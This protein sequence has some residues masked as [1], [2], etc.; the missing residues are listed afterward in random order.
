MDS[1]LYAILGSDRQI[2]KGVEA[3]SATSAV[4]SATPAFPPLLPPSPSSLFPSA[5]FPTI[6]ARRKATAEELGARAKSNGYKRGV[7]GEKDSTRG[8]GR[9][10]KK[11]TRRQ[12]EVGRPTSNL[13]LGND[14]V[15][16]Y[17][18]DFTQILIDLS[19]V[20][21][22]FFILGSWQIIS[23]AGVFQA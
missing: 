16:F 10:N 6:M 18:E 12:H 22:W 11:T 5:A 9:H 3:R 20:A 4:R 23:A 15:V 8:N 14:T 21:A 7:Y 2:L 19:L 13:I 1:L 17:S